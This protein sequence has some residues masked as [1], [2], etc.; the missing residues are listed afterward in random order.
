MSAPI[1][2]IVIPI[3]SGAG[4]FFL[5]RWYRFSVA[6]GTALTLLLSLL[7]WLLPI[8]E[9]IIFG[10]WTIKIG[11][12][13]TV[14][15]RQ[16]ILT[17]T[18]RPLLE[19]IYLLAAM[20][21]ASAFVAHAGRMYIPLGLIITGI[22]TAVPAVDPFLY[23]ALLLEVAALVSVVLLNRPGQPVGRGTFRFLI[24]QTLGMPF[25]LFTGW[26]LTGVEASPGDL[27]LVNRAAIL[28]G[29]GFAFWLAIFPF[30]TWLPMLAEEVHPFSAGF[31]F[32][33][34]P[35]VVMLFGLG[36]LDRY[37]WLREIEQLDNL[38]QLAGILMVLTGGILAAF[39][40][41]LGRMLGFSMM[42]EIGKAILSIS[43]P[44]GLP[45]FFAMILPRAI[46]LAV[47]C[48]ALSAIKPPANQTTL[49]GFSTSPDLRFSN[50]NGLARRQPLVAGSIAFA[51]FSIAGMPILAGFPLLLNLG[52]LLTGTSPVIA[53]LTLLGT[54]GLFV[55]GLRSLAVFL[56]DPGVDTNSWQFQERGA[57]V[58]FLVIG[59]MLILGV[60]LFPQVFLPP[61]ANLAQTFE[62]L[63]VL[64]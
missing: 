59:V 41:H 7:A 8:N 44:A 53:F 11:E 61:L 22:L 49:D 50:L 5:R 10:P 28:L 58:V 23:A 37:A 47:W 54:A 1:L 36:F 21:F 34:I 42:V 29:F 40:H 6:L 15:G 18:D 43:L 27:D 20:W 2:W 14:L 17:N 52:Y 3:I 35:F 9:L 12:Q 38:L 32:L 63:T 60:G 62:R 39:Q 25:L 56:R 46:A 13:L 4:L 26:L 57:V 31:V 55:G 30:H 64:P 51:Q 45:L 48:L 19:V 16:F 33:L 24:F